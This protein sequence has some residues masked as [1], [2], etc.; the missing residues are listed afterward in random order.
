MFSV[1]FLSIE[2]TDKIILDQ[3]SRLGFNTL[4]L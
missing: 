2:E 1:N 3:I 4:F